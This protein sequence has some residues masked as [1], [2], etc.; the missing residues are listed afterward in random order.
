MIP[1]RSLKELKTGEN[2]KIK[3][4]CRNCKNSPDPFKNP[5]CTQEIIR[6]VDSNDNIDKLILSDKYVLEYMKNDVKTVANYKKSV[7]EASYIIR[8]NITHK[9]CKECRN[10][11]ERKI[12]KIFEN[13]HKTPQKGFE[14]LKEFSAEIKKNKKIGPK[15]CKKCRRKLLKEGI[16]PAIN[17]LKTTNLLK[18]EKESEEGN[19][20]LNPAI[21]PRFLRSK[22]KQKQPEN[23]TIKE[24]YTVNGTKIRIFFI[25]E[26][27]E[28][29]YQITP[30]EYNLSSEEIEL[31]IQV[32]KELIEEKKDFNPE[33]AKNLIK[34][35]SKEKLT[36]ISL[37]KDLNLEIEKINELTE[38]AAR[39]TIGLGLIETILQDEKIQDIFADAPLG[40]NPIYIKHQEYGECITNAYLTPHDGEILKS[41]FRTISG[42]PFSESSPS[43]DLN[44]KNIRIAAID[45]PLSPKG[46]ALAVRRHRSTPWTLPLFI[47]NN[48]MTSKAAALLSLLVDSQNSI[49]VTGS[50]GAGKTSLLGALLLE[51]LPK[52]RI[53]CLEDTPELPVKKLKELGFKAQ[54]LQT[55]STVSNSDLEMSADEALKTAL[56]LGESVLAIGEVRGPEAKSLYEA[57]RIGAAGNSV[58]GTIHGSSTRDVFERVVFDLNIPPSSF[59]AT[60][61]I[62]VARPIRERGGVEKVRKLTKIAEVN[63]DWK[64][65]PMEEN[66]FQD[67][68]AFKPKKKTIEPT[69]CLKE[70]NSDVF[71]KIS[72]KWNTSEKK[73]YKN[74]KTRAKIFDF[75]VKKSKKHSS[76]ILMPDFIVKSNTK[77]HSIMEKHRNKGEIYFDKIFS[78]W[79]N[80]FK[81]DLK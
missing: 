45:K 9:K 77:F 18:K 3:I 4:N 15:K 76:R 12:N 17:Q 43:L 19:N 13:L 27:L 36:R 40:K 54:R 70:N 29:I 47:K 72:K 39:Y 75:L 11:R 16:K 53:L 69:T 66:G 58:M 6:K 44:W 50:R 2:K 55:K 81:K 74:F 8:K 25:P 31:L 28:H 59:K 57:M 41:R 21:R 65:N 42:R 20:I 51:I 5:D 22:I 56:R 48:F 34:S 62:A 38:I 26:K 79:K 80:W 7:Q 1:I 32:K 14:K 23:S 67:L 73:V 24:T 78:S 60:D 52:F 63:S 10:E 37:E 33:S 71:E 49:M 64:E 35:K 30:P 46:L 68:M 61:I